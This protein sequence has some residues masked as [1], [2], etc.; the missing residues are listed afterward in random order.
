[1]LGSGR[2]RVVATTCRRETA[3]LAVS[4]REDFLKHGLLV[5]CTVCE[6]VRT[7]RARCFLGSSVP[8]RTQG[9]LPAMADAPSGK[10]SREG[11][12][13]GAKVVR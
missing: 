6:T 7:R 8:R 9:P 1:M 2:V 3:C 12:V 5:A 4:C 13:P 10:P 11:F